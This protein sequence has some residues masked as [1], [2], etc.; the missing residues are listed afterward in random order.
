MSIKLSICI[1]THNRAKFIRDALQSIV[2][3]ASNEIEIVVSDNASDDNT[4]EIV[5]AFKTVFS[6]IT[7]SRSPI[8]LGPDRNF[9]RIIQLAKGEYCWFLGSD[10]KIEEGAIA[11]VLLL[12][13]E[14]PDLTGITVNNSGYDFS[15]KN[16]IFMQPVGDFVEN[17][18]FDS[19]EECFKRLFLNIGFISCQ[20]FKRSLWLDVVAAK[21]VEKYCNA[22]VHLYIMGHMIK[23]ASKWL[24]FH[25]QCIGYRSGNDSFLNRGYFRRLEIDVVGHD[26]LLAELCGR[27]HP[28]Y[29]H[30]ISNLIKGHIRLH[31]RN[32]K[33]A[34]G[35]RGFFLKTFNLCFS[36]YWKLPYF[37]YGLM[38]RLLTPPFVMKSLRILYQKS[39]KKWR[40]QKI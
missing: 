7:Y 8:N 3:Q 30:I 5:E 15:L 29:R 6:Q 11:K 13:K 27:E 31:I 21:D 26:A 2:E 12:L 25:Q 38:P 18:L 10:D 34:H 32:A 24:Y 9:L 1:P 19:W 39:L 17:V 4:Q 23:Q 40:L 20:V 35:E 16:R 36:H 28:L 33:L 14:Q 22:Y 37:W